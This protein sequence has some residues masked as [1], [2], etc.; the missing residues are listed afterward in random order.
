M[1][2]L[3]DLEVKSG[4]EISALAYYIVHRTCGEDRYDMMNALRQRH[5]QKMYN[6]GYK[7]IN[8]RLYH[9]ANL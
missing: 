1:K 5:L 8:K 6:N 4:G 3:I 9:N 2:V 7:E